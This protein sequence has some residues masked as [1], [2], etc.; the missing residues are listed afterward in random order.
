MKALVTTDSECLHDVKQHFDQTGNLRLMCWRGDR[1][2][3]I[4]ISNNGLDCILYGD[5]SL[6]QMI[7][8]L[9]F[10]TRKK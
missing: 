2:E 8:H 6:L 5:S 1:G 3:V 7:Q 10:Q 4:A 9:I